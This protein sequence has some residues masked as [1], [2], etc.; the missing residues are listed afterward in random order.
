M[1]LEGI[2]GSSYGCGWILSDRFG[3]WF[4]FWVLVLFTIWFSRVLLLP[5]SYVSTQCIAHSLARILSSYNTPSFTSPSLPIYNP[6]YPTASFRDSPPAL[7]LSGSPAPSPKAV[8]MWMLRYLDTY[9]L[10]LP[11]YR[12]RKWMEWDG[13]LLTLSVAYC[14]NISQN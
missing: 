8:L 1:P 6:T 7:W 9:L 4:W 13:T 3:L 10:S 11:Y 5:S 12:N 14:S 2:H